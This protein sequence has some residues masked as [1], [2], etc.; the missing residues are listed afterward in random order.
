MNHRVLVVDD[1]KET[2][3]ALAEVLREEGHDART[4]YTA[5]QALAVAPWF[6]PDVA[7][8]DLLLPDMDGSRLAGQLRDLFGPALRLLAFT[9]Q[10]IGQGL[11]PDGFRAFDDVM[12]KPAGLEEI[13]DAL[14]G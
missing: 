5:Q 7:I 14:D 3:E 9:G 10:R 1:S 12:L 4:A 11:A 8:V 6:A 2:A 13:L